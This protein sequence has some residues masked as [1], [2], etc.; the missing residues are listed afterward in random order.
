MSI[1][2]YLKKDDNCLTT[3]IIKA[4]EKTILRM[5]NNNICNDVYSDQNEDNLD[6]DSSPM[7][8][9]KLVMP[10]TEEK[11]ILSTSD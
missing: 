1:N 8:K 6:D 3:R 11:M 4:E 5:H 7:F 10:D 2:D 9:N